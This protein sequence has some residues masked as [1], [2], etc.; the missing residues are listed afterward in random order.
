MIREERGGK[1]SMSGRNETICAPKS[2]PVTFGPCGRI[3]EQSGRMRNAE[4]FLSMC[5][6]RPTNAEQLPIKRKMTTHG[7]LRPQRTCVWPIEVRRQRA[8][9]LAGGPGPTFSPSS[10]RELFFFFLY[11][12]TLV[13]TSSSLYNNLRL[14]FFLLAREH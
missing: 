14:N 5:L 2:H 1:K 11:Y 4:S 3:G 13:G 12:Y 10:S 6:K 7:A 9:E 8:R